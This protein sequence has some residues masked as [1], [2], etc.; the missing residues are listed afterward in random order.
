V[1]ESRDVAFARLDPAFLAE[2]RRR[3]SLAELISS[4]GIVAL[5]RVGRELRGLCPFHK[6]RTPSFYV[7]EAKGFWHCFGCGE[8]GDCFAWVTKTRHADFRDAAMWLA[9]CAGIVAGEG[10]GTPR[11][12]PVVCRPAAEMLEARD[13]ARI[14]AARAIWHSRRM[15]QGTPAERYWC[16]RRLWL[17]MPPTIGFVQR[18]SHPFLR[19]NAAPYPAMVAAIQAPDDGGRKRVTGV[20]CT[21]LPRHGEPADGKGRALAPSSWAPDRQWKAKLMRGVVGG[22]AVRLTAAEDLMVIGEGIET[23][24]SLLQGLYDPEVGAPHVDGEPV[25]VWAALS[26]SNLGTIWLPD[27]VREVILAADSDGKIPD[28][29]NPRQQD[30]DAILDG[31]AA[32]HADQGRA[33]RLA[34]PPTGSDFNDLLPAGAGAGLASEDDEVLPEHPA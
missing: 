16:G 6:E 29:D 17:P 33:V 26:Q 13:R 14:T 15:P 30:P 21:Y 11:A 9:A 7:V 34:K 2:I 31:A 25:G 18:L 19:P 23:S 28:A 8:N 12:R 27:H 32:R 5:K 4:S 1:P 22:G 3:T 24:A 10:G 20:H